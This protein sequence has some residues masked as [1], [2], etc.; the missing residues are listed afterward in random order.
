MLEKCNDDFKIYIPPSIKIYFTSHV[1]RDFLAA[2]PSDQ[3][4]YTRPV[5]QAVRKALGRHLVHN[6]SAWGS[7]LFHIARWLSSLV[8]TE[9]FKHFFIYSAR[10]LLH[11]Q[12]LATVLYNTWLCVCDKRCQCLP[13]L[14]HGGGFPRGC[15]IPPT[16]LATDTD[17]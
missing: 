6:P 17:I 5:P 2:P 12:V 7:I 3:T 13:P 10:P 9:H 8:F 15:C 11:F 1:M 16:Q 14:L 4:G